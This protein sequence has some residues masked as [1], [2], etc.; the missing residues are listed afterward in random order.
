VDCG[1]SR[2]KYK[3]AGGLLHLLALPR[4]CPSE[5]PRII[6]YQPVTVDRWL[7]CESARQRLEAVELAVRLRLQAT[8]ALPLLSYQ[9][10]GN[11]DVG[12]R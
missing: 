8:V 11:A 9:Q 5:K 10:L 3:P 4:P 6:D 7:S 12:D 1:P 2:R